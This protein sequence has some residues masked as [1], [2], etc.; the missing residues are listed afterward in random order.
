MT[1]KRKSI[2]TWITVALL[3]FLGLAVIAIRGGY[4]PTPKSLQKQ[5]A[6]TPLPA[7][8]RDERWQQAVEYLGEQLPYLHIDPYFKIGKTDFQKSVRQ[9]SAEIPNLNDEQIIVE[10]MRITASIGDGHTR[11]YPELDPVNFQR[12]PLVTRWLDDGLIVVAASPEYEQSIGNKVVQIGKYPIEVVDNAVRPLIA[13]DNHMQLLSNSPAYIS[14]PAVLYGLGL[15][16][17]KDQVSFIFEAQDGSN[18]TLDLEPALWPPETIVTIY[19]KTDVQT[20][21]YEQD[22]R[23]YYWYQHLPES[24]TVYVQY[25]VCAEQD[26]KPFQPFVDEVFNLVDQNPDTRLV[27]DVRF[28]GGGNGAVLFP[29][30]D[31]IKAR[32]SVNTKGKLFVITGRWT[33]SSA[34]QNAI[35]LQKDTNAILVGEPTGGKP[36]HYGEIRSFT[37]PNVG[38]RVQYSTRYWLT[39]PAKDPLTLE[40]DIPVGITFADMLAGRDPVLEAILAQP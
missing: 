10:M 15:I 5:P 24:N 35:M 7:E 12:I 26:G 20:P 29:F 18:F 28:N 32:P 21:L 1:K 40:P 8:T 37:L 11:S 19:E 17:Q 6:P 27:L 4:A 31:A 36:N 14:M 34:L 2:I 23:S 3:L 16:P 30:I 9:L 39:Y 22:K 38:L 25:N 33:Y 13:A